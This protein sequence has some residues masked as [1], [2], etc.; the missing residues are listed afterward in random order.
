M[1]IFSEQALCE[2]CFWHVD[3]SV[4]GCLDSVIRVDGWL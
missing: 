1:E 4:V 2:A 3:G